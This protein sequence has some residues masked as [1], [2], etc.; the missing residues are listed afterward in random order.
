MPCDAAEC[1]PAHEAE[2]QDAVGGFGQERREGEQRQHTAHGGPGGHEDLLPGQAGPRALQH[3]LLGLP[4]RGQEGLQ[5]ALG[6][7]TTHEVADGRHRQADDEGEPEHH[8]S[9]L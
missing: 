3:V 6:V 8:R 1:R 7:G 5:L 4:P 9:F 2:A